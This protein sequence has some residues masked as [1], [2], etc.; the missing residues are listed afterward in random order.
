MSYAQSTAK[1]HIRAKQ[2]VFLP[3]PQVKIVIHYLFNTQST[4]E[5]WRNL[6]KMKFNEPGR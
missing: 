5:D 3:L 6:G 4:V 2:I 1:G